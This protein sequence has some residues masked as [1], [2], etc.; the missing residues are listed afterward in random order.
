M[1]RARGFKWDNVQKKQFVVDSNGVE[2]TL[3]DETGGDG[4]GAGA[5][6]ETSTTS[7]SNPAD[8]DLWF[9][10]TDG[11]MYVY[12]DD[13]TSSQWVGISGASGASI[14]TST[15]L[16]SNPA[17]GDLWFDTT[18]GTMY[19]YYDDGTSSQWVGISGATGATG[20]GG[21]VTIYADITARNAA[22]GV[23]EGD[24]AFVSDSDTLYVYDSSEWIRILA[25]P[26]ELPR[27]TTELSSAIALNADGTAT[28]LTVAATD[29]DGFDIKYTYDTSP[30]NQTQA[31]IVNNNDG[32]F[33]LT[34]SITETDTGK[35]TFRAKATDGIHVISSTSEVAL[36]FM[37]QPASNIGWFD[38]SNPS[39]Y[40]GTG[41]VLTNIAYGTPASAT[42]IITPGSGSFLT[43]GT[44]GV[45]VFDF[46]DTTRTKIVFSN[47]MEQS[48]KTIMVSFSAP[49]TFDSIIM[50]GGMANLGDYVGTFM[51]GQTTYLVNDPAVWAG[52]I[53]KVY[54]NGAL[55]TTPVQARNALDLTGT[56]FNSLI[57]TGY[58]LYAKV[59]M[60]YHAYND[61]QWGSDH[62]VLGFGMWD[63]VLSL[64]DLEK[65][66][67]LLAGT[68]ITAPWA[69]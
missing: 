46:K 66:H 21:G 27:W 56:K 4:G 13:G 68:S 20:T 49:N 50:W 57:I 64:S 26:D 10:T 32:T 24:I 15:T 1:A 39:S 29:P 65:A 43:S 5:S 25:G 47:E 12:Y 62:Q 60:D 52:E 23:N 44:A 22:T 63:T 48:A 42:E 58:N 36:S 30:S 59:G 53:G 67:T 31:T 41:N 28:T 6:I 2:T 14:E 8:G 34:P 55:V 40:S 37:P 54:V 33:T 69:G 61:S 38:F 16:P 7:P 9:D 11:T 19:V 17:D 51:D 45:K 35:F 18:D 3:L